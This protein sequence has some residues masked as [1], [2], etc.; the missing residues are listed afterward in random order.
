MAYDGQVTSAGILPFT[1]IKRN[2][3]R[4]V[5]V[6][7]G[8]ERPDPSWNDSDKWSDFGGKREREESV[9]DAAAREFFEETCGV[10]ES[11]DRIKQR[12]TRLDFGVFRDVK[13]SPTRDRFY[14]M[15]LLPVR[16][17]QYRQ[18]FRN[19][20]DYLRYI[21]VDPKHVEKS[22]MTWI[23]WKDLVEDI[24][25]EPFQ[26]WDNRRPPLRLR[27]KFQTCL[28]AFAD[29]RHEDLLALY[30]RWIAPTPI[31]LLPNG[32]RFQAE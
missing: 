14:R 30:D 20:T 26:R 18:L 4:I 21:D 22:E 27:G 9:E 5:L 13:I 29:V 16:F 25:R 1:V 8:R 31:S 3:N 24:D 10:V 17:C 23:S 11:L 7:L 19:V 28:R 15:Y 32:K 6:L 2:G 12:L